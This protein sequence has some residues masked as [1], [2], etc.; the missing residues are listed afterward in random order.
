MAVNAMLG[1]GA[2]LY[3]SPDGITYTELVDMQEIG[4][5]DDPEVGSVDATPVNPT[6]RAHEFLAGL[7][8]YGEF[9]FKQYFTGP[10][11]VHH[12]GNIYK[13]VYYKIVLNDLISTAGSTMIIQTFLMKARL[14]TLEAEKVVT[15]DC[16][17]KVTGASTF[18]TAT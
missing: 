1:L 10:R 6:N 5:P 8:N 14:S 3:D 15:I 18:T 12:R 4:S 11:L 7:I 2:R 13:T 16:K 17:A 9:E